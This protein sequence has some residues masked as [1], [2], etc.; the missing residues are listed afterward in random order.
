MKAVLIQ[1][2]AI[3]TSESA[4]PLYLSSVNDA[5]V[6]H[7]NAVEW[8]P[9]IARL[10]RLRYDFF[11]GTFRGQIG[12]PQAD[13][14]VSIN[15]ITD[16][17]DRVFSLA[18]VRVYQGEV[19]DAWGSYTLKFDGQ[20]TDDPE[21]TAGIA[22]FRAAPDDEWLDEPFMDV[23]EGTGGIEGPD[24]L[25]GIVKPRV[26]GNC[27]FVPGVLIDT[28]D[29]V[30]MVNDGAVEGISAA[31]DRA[32][33]LGTSTGDY[34]S[35]AA[36]IAASIPAG[37]WGTCKALG[38]VRLGAPPD[39]TPAFDVQ[40]DNVSGY[41][42]KPGAIISRIAGIAGG[43]VNSSNMTAL[44]TDRP[45]NLCYAIST[46]TTARIAIQ[47]IA[48]S[49][50]ASVGISWTG[51]L[52]AQGLS[53]DASPSVELNSDGTSATVVRS[54]A[55][56]TLGAPFKRLATYA[57]PTFVVYAPSE[58]ATGYTI[59]GEYSAART[60]RLDDLVSDDNGTLW[61]Y[62]NSTPAAGQALPTWPATSNSYWS[63]YSPA[64][65]TTVV[66]PPPNAKIYA[67]YDG[68]A[69]A[70][71]LPVTANF[72]LLEK[73]VDKTAD[74]TWG[75]TLLNGDATFTISNASGS[76]GRLSITA[77]ASDYAQIQIEGTLYG[78]T[79]TIVWEVEKILDTPPAASG[80]GT[81]DS[82][83]IN[84][85][86]VSSSWVAI[87]DEITVTAGSAGD[88]ELTVTGG[89][90]NISYSATVN[91]YHDLELRFYEDD[92][93]G[94]AAI[95]AA[96]PETVGAYLYY[97]GAPA[98]P[99][100]YPGTFSLTHTEN[101]GAG[102]TSNFKLYARAT[103]YTSEG[104]DVYAGTISGAGS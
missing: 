74:A 14:S 88:V 25:T 29:V 42:R 35:L 89:R 62:V 60:Y 47:Q 9:N 2:D 40:G 79:R 96:T 50:A 34:A 55:G 6:V 59:R 87:S 33:S 49:V 41:V 95:G 75:T 15:G 99:A 8:L 70:N 73:G 46:Q 77:L 48:D 24:D 18:R 43:T 53:I 17:F 31:Y 13:F 52:F 98:I 28:T 66:I 64:E 38:L 45:Y 82:G 57:E 44:D 20:V 80:G 54:V 16:F 101:I 36:L 39:G 71:Q 94:Y 22:T 85:S 91:Q 67:L 69:K 1:I 102:N 12:R 32:V 37:G 26:F 97:P 63:L 92:G 30:Y 68:T 21:V 58:V 23:F 84:Y 104:R 4:L 3:D 61:A 10:P 19:G 103:N 83:A 100:L 51:E 90:F 11:G 93:G 65:V 27:R 86:P 76:E 78:V 72:K 5:S 81:S 56:R 7:L